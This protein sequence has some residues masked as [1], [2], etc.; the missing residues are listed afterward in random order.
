MVLSRLFTKDET[1]LKGWI[2]SLR[3]VQSKSIHKKIGDGLVQSVAYPGWSTHFRDEVQKGGI[4]FL[5]DFFLAKD[6]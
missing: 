6:P 2:K 1:H 4:Q 3:Y 5:W